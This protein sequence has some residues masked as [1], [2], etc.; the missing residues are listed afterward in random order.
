MRANSFFLFA[1]SLFLVACRS[2]EYSLGAVSLAPTLPAPDGLYWKGLQGSYTHFSQIKVEL[3]NEGT[4]SIFLNPTYPQDREAHLERF[5][6]A[7]KTWELGENGKA[8]CVNPYNSLIE[9]KTGSRKD[10]EV[11]WFVAFSVK[12]HT[13]FY[14]TGFY[15]NEIGNERPLSGKYRLTLKYTKTPWENVANPKIILNAK[16]PEFVI[17]WDEN[18]EVKNGKGGC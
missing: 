16:S 12:D 7:T 18:G 6:E 13:K 11:D 15:G 5:N 2:V 8:L 4:D 10:V 17:N 9:I 14:A 1:I 3:S